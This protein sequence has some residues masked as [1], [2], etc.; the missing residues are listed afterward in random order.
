MKSYRFGVATL[1]IVVIATACLHYASQTPDS[2][3]KTKMLG[4]TYYVASNGSDAH[5]GTPSAPFRTIQKCASVA[6]AGD[7]CLIGAGTYRETVTPG[8]SGTAASP[9]TFA[10]HN[11]AS[12]TINGADVV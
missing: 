4:K 9:I 11:G 6:T 5:A 12:V 3:L 7:T 2:A 8:H 10:P 1:L